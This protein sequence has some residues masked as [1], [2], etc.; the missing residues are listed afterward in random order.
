MSLKK[1]INLFYDLSVWF[2]RKP[3]FTTCFA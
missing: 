2:K 1:K 3:S